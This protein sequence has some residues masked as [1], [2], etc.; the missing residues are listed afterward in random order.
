MEAIKEGFLIEYL[1]TWTFDCHHCYEVLWES[2]NLRTFVFEYFGHHHWHSFRK[3]CQK[4][5]II[6]VTMQKSQDCGCFLE[7]DNSLSHLNFTYLSGRLAVAN[8]FFN[9]TNDLIHDFTWLL[10][11]FMRI[12]KN[13]DFRYNP[14]KKVIVRQFNAGDN[15]KNHG[16]LLFTDSLLT[17]FFTNRLHNIEQ[18]Q[19]YPNHFVGLF[20]SVVGQ[21]ASQLS[22]LCLLFIF[23]CFLRCWRLHINGE[24]LE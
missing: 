6:E 23:G 21:F 19:S 12:Q 1:L 13:L 14:N 3:W 7:L 22:S 4:R 9:F 16:E 10:R 24:M 15:C 20:W 2:T 5:F 17:R 18:S 11:N 8:I